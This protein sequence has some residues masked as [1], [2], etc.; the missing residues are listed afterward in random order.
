MRWGRCSPWASEVQGQLST[1][2][3]FNTWLNTWIK[4]APM[5]TWTKDIN[6]DPIYIRT[7]DPDMITSSSLNSVVTML[8]VAVWDSQ[9]GM[10][11]SVAWLPDSNIDPVSHMAS[12]NRRSHRYQHRP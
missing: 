5:V 10:G 8:W 11:P 3:Y 9:I 2:L 1:A 12:N 4:W 6:T 7:M